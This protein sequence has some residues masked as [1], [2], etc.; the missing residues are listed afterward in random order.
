MSDLAVLA[1]GLG[2]TA[3]LAVVIY[4]ALRK[5][6]PGFIIVPNTGFDGEQFIVSTP[7][8]QAVV[9][10]VWSDEHGGDCY[11][12]ETAFGRSSRGARAPRLH[13]YYVAPSKVVVRNTLRTLVE[14]HQ[15]ERGARR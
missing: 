11:E 8:G 10:R 14:Q 1:V 2:V 13:L 15:A 9:T 3:A 12:I 6:G 4:Y 7:A 5:A